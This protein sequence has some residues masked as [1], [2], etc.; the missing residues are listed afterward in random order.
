[1]MVKINFYIYIIKQLLTKVVAFTLASS[2]L[3]LSSTFALEKHYCCNMLVDI[4]I[5]GQTKSCKDMAEQKDSPFKKC[6]DED[7]SCC[8]DE[9]LVKK[10]EDKLKHIDL[11]TEVANEIFII[12]FLQSYIN[13]YEGTDKNF[14]LYEDYVPPLISKDLLILYETFLI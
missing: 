11:Q 13:L 7:D 9:V 12:A 4:A 3:F 1:M 6:S 5:L 10:G 2:I 8:K 14:T